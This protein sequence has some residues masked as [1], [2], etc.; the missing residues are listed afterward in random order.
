MIGGPRRD[1]D[2]QVAAA[3]A[4]HPTPATLDELTPRQRAEVDRLAAYRKTTPEAV[5]EALHDME[6]A[7]KAKAD[8]T[9]FDPR[10]FTRGGRRF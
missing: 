1:I 7:E 5:L 9:A 2:A 6:A 10:D 8:G 3:V 4:A